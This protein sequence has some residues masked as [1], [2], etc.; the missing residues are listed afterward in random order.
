MI[1]EDCDHDYKNYIRKGRADLRCSKCGKD[2]TLELVIMADLK[3]KAN[4]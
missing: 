1:K 4:K 2:I 3:E